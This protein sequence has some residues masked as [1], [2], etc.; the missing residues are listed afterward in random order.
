MTFSVLSDLNWLAV[1]VA[2]VS[3]FGLAGPWFAEATLGPAW[4]RSIGWEKASGQRLSLPDYVGPLA[5]CLVAV[6]AVAMLA[7]A[8]GS[9]NLTEG[10]VLGL[11]VGVGIAGAILFVTGVLDPTKPG[12]A[13]WFGI[14]AGNRM[15]GLLIA[16]TIVS[17]WT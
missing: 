12:P 16:S 6:I 17:V 4:R 2:T 5:T 8:T 1:I 13:A 15:L 3:Y 7:D 14:M 11:V 10:I 9:T